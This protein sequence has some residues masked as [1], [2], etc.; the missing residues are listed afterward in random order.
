MAFFLAQTY[1]IFASVSTT[2]FKTFQCDRYGDDSKFYLVEDHQ[3]TIKGLTNA[4]KFSSTSYWKYVETLLHSDEVEAGWQQIQPEVKDSEFTDWVNDYGVDVE[5]RC[6]DGNGPIDQIRAKFMVNGREDEVR[7]YLLNAS[8]EQ[9]E[10]E[11]E[12][13]IISSH[14][15]KNLK[16]YYVAKKMIFPFNERDFMMEEWSGSCR[17]WREGKD[18]STMIIA[19]IDER[20]HNE[21]SSANLR[22]TRGKID[23]FAFL[24]EPTGRGNIATNITFIGGGFDMKGYL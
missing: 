18:K 11:S 12:R 5:W 21:K 8:N 7:K 24:L 19:S 3:G 9:H 16:R 14:S 4:E 15:E 20:R 23:I 2:L 13:S 6:S 22:R 17:D 1:L 10:D